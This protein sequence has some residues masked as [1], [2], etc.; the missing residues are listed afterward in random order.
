MKLIKREY[1]K[2]TWWYYSHSISLFFSL[3]S[4]CFNISISLL[5]LFASSFYPPLSLSHLSL[6]LWLSCSIDHSP[7]PFTIFFLFR[8]TPPIDHLVSRFCR[9]KL[10]A[11]PST[12]WHYNYW[13]C[14]CV[15]RKILCSNNIWNI[16]GPSVC[17]YREF[18]SDNLHLNVNILSV[19]CIAFYIV[20][21][22]ELGLLRKQTA[23][24]I[25]THPMCSS[26]NLRKRTKFNPINTWTLIEHKVFGCYN[27]E[28][29]WKSLEICLLHE[30]VFLFR[31]PPIELA[32]CS[33][34][35]PRHSAAVCKSYNLNAVLLIHVLA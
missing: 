16:W 6:S 31:M 30:D 8:R 19:C 14:L 7:L 11:L 33:Y 4:T 1:E 5:Y 17:R 23:D 18:A 22:R 25:H 3:P 15:K 35:A 34:I 10:L 28:N 12:T 21:K 2:F 9:S 29:K 24:P 13:L 27:I 32:G 26:Y 20:M